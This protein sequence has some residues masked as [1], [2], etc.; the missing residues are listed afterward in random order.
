MRGKGE[1]LV[2][3]LDEQ[4]PRVVVQANFAL[5]EDLPVLVPEDRE[6]HFVL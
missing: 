6:E 1:T 3:E 5:F 2:V 4:G